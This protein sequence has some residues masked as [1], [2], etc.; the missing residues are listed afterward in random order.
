MQFQVLSVV[1]WPKNPELKPRIVKFEPGCVNVITG[2]SKTGKTAI[3]PIIDY[4]LGAEKCA[5]PVE[6]IR[7]CTSWFGLVAQTARGQLLLARR[8]PGVQKS[9][10]DMFVLE[11][12][13]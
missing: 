6:T 1:L 8:E 2:A 10:S 9:T 4:C 13:V 5:I 7:N 3:I 11:G 12:E